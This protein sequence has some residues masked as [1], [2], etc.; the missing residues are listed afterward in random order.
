[1]AG[2]SGRSRHYRAHHLL[3]TGRSHGGRRYGGANITS[4]NR[5]R[6]DDAAGVKN[7][8]RFEEAFGALDIIPGAAAAKGSFKSVATIRQISSKT[9]RNVVQSFKDSKNIWAN[10]MKVNGLKPK[11]GSND[12]GFAIKKQFAKSA[13]ALSDIARGGEAGAG[14]TLVR[15]GS[16]YSAH[17]NA[18]P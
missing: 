17:V 18:R 15:K 16:N 10:R 6:F 12:A 9:D 13:D 5:K 2:S 7:R 11:T 1:M 14:G 3:R 8:R 4:R